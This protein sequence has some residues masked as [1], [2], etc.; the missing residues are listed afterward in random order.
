MSSTDALDVKTLVGDLPKTESMIDLH[1]I[2]PF[3]CKLLIGGAVAKPYYTS[4]KDD[5]D[6]RTPLKSDTRFVAVL[7]MPFS[8]IVKNTNWRSDVEYGAKVHTHTHTR[9]YTR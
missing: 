7:G 8:V 5:H 9:T 1:G 2:A 6:N 4:L 3:T